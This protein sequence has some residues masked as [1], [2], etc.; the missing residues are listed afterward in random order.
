MC[1]PLTH[2]SAKKA[3]IVSKRLDDFRERTQPQL[4]RVHDPIAET[5]D[6]PEGHTFGTVVRPDEVNAGELMH[7][8]GPTTYQECEGF[9]AGVLASIRHHL[10][11]NNFYNFDG[12]LD[13]MQHQDKVM[14]ATESCSGL[15]MN[16]VCIADQQKCVHS[17]GMHG[18]HK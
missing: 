18:S 17:N 14:A 9:D 15:G 8:V 5:L 12:L 16:V 7:M 4:G 11:K 1:R 6:V 10:K 2:P 3:P 13:A